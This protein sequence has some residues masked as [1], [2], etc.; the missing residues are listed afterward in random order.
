MADAETTYELDTPGM[1]DWQFGEAEAR[2]IRCP[3][4]S[5]LGEKSNALWPRFGETHQALLS[6]MPQTEEFILPGS[7]HFLEMENPIDLAA[8]LAAFFGRHPLKVLP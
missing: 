8:G 7:H 6:W 5:V 1:L 4:L 3:I 2:R